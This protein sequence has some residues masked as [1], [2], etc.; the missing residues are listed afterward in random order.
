MS[1]SENTAHRPRVQCLG[2]QDPMPKN[3]P[4]DDPLETAAE[5]RRQMGGIT[6]M[7]EWRWQ[8]R[9]SELKPIKINGRNYYRRSQREAFVKA[10]E[11]EVV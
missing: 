3:D 7:T 6:S 1:D 11:R 10:R 2:P 4:L 9:Y 8:Q 5:F